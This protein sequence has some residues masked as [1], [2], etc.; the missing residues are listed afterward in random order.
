M[1]G[2]GRPRT[3][4][5]DAGRR[6][7]GAL[8]RR[9]TALGLTRESLSNR[10]SIS[11]N[12]IMAIEQGKVADPGFFT[13]AALA[14]TL[15]ARLDD[16]LQDIRTATDRG[17][18]EMTTGIVSVGYEGR[19]VDELVAEL[20][21]LGTSTLVDVRLNAVSRRPGFS[22]RA[23]QET[24][25]EA[26]IRYVHLRK[27]GNPRENRPS[28]QSDESETG[29]RRFARLLRAK[30]AQAELQELMQLAEG[31]VVA[32]LCVE[33]D[34][35]HCHRAVIIEELRQRRVTMPVVAVS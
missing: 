18:K 9:R 25:E 20:Q 4:R 10:A 2:R 22:K 35:L 1:D 23:L 16:L 29:R 19:T 3:A 34:E 31:G 17:S 14:S 26:G 12:T 30:Q 13:V 15:R 28:F 11:K 24:L 5:A 32:V 6:L 27:L 21:R 33:R 8:R 7:A